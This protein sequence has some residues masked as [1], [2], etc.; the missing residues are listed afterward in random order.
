MVIVSVVVAP[1]AVGVKVAVPNVAVQ[2]VGRAGG[3]SVATGA[4]PSSEVSVT[5]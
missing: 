3:V 5:I 2:P 4:K 1:A